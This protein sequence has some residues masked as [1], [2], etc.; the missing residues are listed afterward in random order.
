VTDISINLLANCAQLVKNKI[1]F[2][3]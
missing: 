2:Y 1:H 3:N